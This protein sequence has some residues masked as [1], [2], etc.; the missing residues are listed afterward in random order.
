MISREIY[1][2]FLILNI[3]FFF[4][5]F[6]FA[7]KFIFDVEEIEITDNGNIYKGYNRGII[8]TNKGIII[9]ADKFTYNKSENIVDAEGNVKF[10]DVNKYKIFSNQATYKKIRKNFNNRKF[11]SY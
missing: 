6:A 2:F 8:K 7:E 9:K 4:N 3:F 10:L 11:N 5:C 1:K